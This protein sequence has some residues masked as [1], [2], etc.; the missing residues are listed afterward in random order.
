MT[1]ETG[2]ATYTA[3]THIRAE[4]YTLRRAARVNKLE[5]YAY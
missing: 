2:W 1:N 5:P 4:M 3:A